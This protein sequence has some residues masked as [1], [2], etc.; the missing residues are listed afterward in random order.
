MYFSVLNLCPFTCS[1][2]GESFPT[3]Y[4][5]YSTLPPWMWPWDCFR[6]APCTRFL[7][8]HSRIIALLSPTWRHPNCRIW[9]CMV[10]KATTSALTATCIHFRQFV[11]FLTCLSIIV[12]SWFHSCVI[13]RCSR[14]NVWLGLPHR[15]IFA[16]GRLLLFSPSG[17]RNFP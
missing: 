2:S 7:N 11:L 8:T 16:R 6:Y 14:S 13:A 12:N 1:T 17:R 15:T 5:T 10:V 4:T 9:G 3:C